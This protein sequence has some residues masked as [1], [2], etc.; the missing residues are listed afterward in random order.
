MF[1]HILIA[2]DGSAEARS[3]GTDH[4]VTCAPTLNEN[5]RTGY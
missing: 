1:D 4:A 5:G 3:A 2:L